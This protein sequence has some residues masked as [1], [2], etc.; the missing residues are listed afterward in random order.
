[1]ELIK[2]YVEEMINNS[3][4]T[5]DRLLIDDILD[6]SN[7]VYKSYEDYVEHKRNIV[8]MVRKH[9]NQ[10]LNPHNENYSFT[11]YVEP[12]ILSKVVFYYIVN[13]CL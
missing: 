9:N 11:Y 13:K 1:M 12:V 5:V 3:N 4:N 6:I 2:E 10:F 8:D 7:G